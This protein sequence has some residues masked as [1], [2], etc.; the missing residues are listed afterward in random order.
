MEPI[1]ALEKVPPHT[2]PAGIVP[3]LAPSI[4]PQAILP[5]GSVPINLPS[6]VPDMMEDALRLVTVIRLASSVPA[7]IDSA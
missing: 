3:I 5:P 1:N 4:V 2:L 6:I 7:N